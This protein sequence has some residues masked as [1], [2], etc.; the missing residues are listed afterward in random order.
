[1]ATDGANTIYVLV[2][3]APNAGLIAYCGGWTY[4]DGAG[5]VYAP[6][7]EVNAVVTGQ[8]FGDYTEFKIVFNNY[9]YI[10]KTCEQFVIVGHDES[11]LAIISTGKLPPLPQI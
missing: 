5:D 8:T 2:N 3:D 10:T 4:H 9:D 6:I 7:P 11:R 1:M